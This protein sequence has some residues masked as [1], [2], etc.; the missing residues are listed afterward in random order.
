MSLLAT[1]ALSVVLA[2]RTVL[3]AVSLHVGPG[4][5]IGLIGPNGAGKSTLLKAVLGLIPARGGIALA[6]G[7]GRAMTARRRAEIAAYLPQ[8]REVHWPVSVETLVGLARGY[9]RG[10]LA[11]PSPH[12]RALVAAA[13]QRMDV[14]ALRARR[15]TELSGG[16]RARVLIARALAQDTPLLLADEPTAGLDP[17][18]QIALMATFAALAR[19]GRSVV[20]CLH[21]IALAARW[22]TRIVVLDG[23]RLVADGPPGT[24]LEATLMRDVYGVEI[25]RSD[26]KDG[27]IVLPTALSGGHANDTERP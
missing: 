21:D 16:E 26:G 2:G 11:G 12:D 24:V 19:E 6:G 5:C 13:M 7:D 17:A 1:D 23:G 9:V 4:E 3:D 25:H 15:A 27:L 8:E 10:P 14:A 20:A 18:H 22:C